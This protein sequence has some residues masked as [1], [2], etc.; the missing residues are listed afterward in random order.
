ME[1]RGTAIILNSRKYRA[2]EDN[3]EEAKR[4]T[5]DSPLPLVR[6]L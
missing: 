3:A 4:T 1:E 5:S 2:T 6:P